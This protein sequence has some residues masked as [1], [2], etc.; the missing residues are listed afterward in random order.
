MGSKRFY[1]NT[2]SD[3][4][5]LGIVVPKRW[6]DG[7]TRILRDMYMY[8]LCRYMGEYLENEMDG[9]GVYVWQSGTYDDLCIYALL[10]MLVKGNIC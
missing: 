8:I 10:L 2:L 6:T 7:S 5:F 9:Y 3:R 4:Y 1:L